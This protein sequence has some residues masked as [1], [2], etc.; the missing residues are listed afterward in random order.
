M[1][2]I[3]YI[4]AHFLDADSFDFSLDFED[5]D[6]DL[7]KTYCVSGDDYSEGVSSRDS[8][9]LVDFEIDTVM[10]R[11]TVVNAVDE[12]WFSGNPGERLG[13]THKERR[14]DVAHFGAPK[15][16]KN[17]I[18]R[19][20]ARM[21]MNTING[22]DLP[23]LQDFS[24][25]F[26]LPSSQFEASLKFSGDFGLPSVLGGRGPRALVHHLLGCFVMFPDM[27][28]TMGDTQI[29]T[30]TH[31]TGTKIVIPWDCKFTITH[32]IPAV[33]WI[34]PSDKA[35]QMY[36]EPSIDKM[37]AA[38]SLTDKSNPHHAN[39]TTSIS[40]FRDAYSQAPIPVKKK[41]KRSNRPT[42][43]NP[44][45]CEQ[46]PASYAEKLISG[47]APV[48]YTPTLS[49]RGSYTIMLDETNRVQSIFLDFHE[50]PQAANPTGTDAVP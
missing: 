36:A 20:F 10:V 22:G 16:L 25:A 7:H 24:T 33:C 34:P 37:M 1:L 42:P 11:Q 49:A 38:L 45:L 3:K 35:E 30:S 31:W 6:S 40:G 5:A 15:V 19:S 23:M 26:I 46:V 50:V 48:A 41:R 8:D 29:I 28:G 14:T 47:A 18:R 4:F 17:D 13:H 43:G 39:E 32:R 44:T 27:V 9:S 2:L 21:F 12:D